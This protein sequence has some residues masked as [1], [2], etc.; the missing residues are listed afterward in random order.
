MI[1][2]SDGMLGMANRS[3]ICS[4]IAAACPPSL[5]AHPSGWA[6]SSLCE[7]NGTSALVVAD[8][9]SSRF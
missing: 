2:V 6:P 8:P 1:D 5:C 4:K 9:S 7:E 3:G